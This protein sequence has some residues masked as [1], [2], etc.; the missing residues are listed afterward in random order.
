MLML[1]IWLYVASFYISIFAFN[2]INNKRAYDL[3]FGY[4]PLNWKR[5]VLLFKQQLYAPTKWFF[6]EFILGMNHFEIMVESVEY[7]KQKAAQRQRK[8]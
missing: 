7:C 2:M 5:F 1:K 8:S 3:V 6:Y 4:K